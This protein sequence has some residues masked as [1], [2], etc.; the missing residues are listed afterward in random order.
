MATNYQT[1]TATIEVIFSSEVFEG[2]P[3][4]IYQLA[5]LEKAYMEDKLMSLV[6][7]FDSDD[8]QA[9]FIVTSVVPEIVE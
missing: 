2:D 9:A 7:A 3:D 6:E 5:D 1:Y 8:R 4:D